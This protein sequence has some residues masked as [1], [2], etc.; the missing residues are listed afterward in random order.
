MKALGFHRVACGEDGREARAIARELNKQLDA[1]RKQMKAARDRAKRQ[2][3][4]PSRRL[5]HLLA[6]WSVFNAERLTQELEER[7]ERKRARSAPHLPGDFSSNSVPRYRPVRP[8]G[9]MI[10][11]G[12]DVDFI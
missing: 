2:R 4:P 5:D 8:T 11:R 12:A 3:H 10:F 7:S 1:E 6:D 9:P